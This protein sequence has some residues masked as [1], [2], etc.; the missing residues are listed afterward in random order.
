[1]HEGPQVEKFIEGTEARA[2]SRL[3]E[4]GGGEGGE[5]REG[6]RGWV[7]WWPGSWSGV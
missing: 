1:M 2:V 3:R 4:G 7:A 5:G 6:R